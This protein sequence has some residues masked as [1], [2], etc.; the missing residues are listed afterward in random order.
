LEKIETKDRKLKD[1]IQ[2]IADKMSRIIFKNPEQYLWAYNR[3][4]LRI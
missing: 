3:F 1:I 2:L 4:N